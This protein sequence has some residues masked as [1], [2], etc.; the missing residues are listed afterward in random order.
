[1]DFSPAQ[2]LQRLPPY[3]FAE[4]DRRKRAAIAAGRDIIDFG[5][6][7]PEQ[8]TYAYIRERMRQALDDPANHRYPL[9]GGSPAFRQAIAAFFRRRYGVTIAP[10]REVLALL[11]SK[12]GLGHL[13]LAVVDPGQTVLIP[14]P[15]YPVY[16]SSTIFAGATPHVMPLT[17]QR[18]WLPD[19]DA[20]PTAVARAAKLMYLNYPNNPTGAMA[21]REF[22]AQAVAFAR[23]HNII[24]AHDAAYNDMYFDER[25]RPPS[26]LEVPEA[27]EVAVELHSLSK[28]FNMTGWRIGFAVGNADVLAA[29]AKIKANL[30]SGVFGAIQEAGIEAYAGIDRPE[31]TQ[32]LRLYRQRADILAQGLREMGFRVAPPR[33]TFYIWAGLP[34]GYDSMAAAARLLEEADIVCVPGVGFGP[35]GDGYIR[36]ALTV[37]TERTH[38]AIVR[39]RKLRW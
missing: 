39:M 20:I 6:G 26:V 5:V 11:G 31:R 16:H 25:D 37:D 4:I 7:D 36:F 22:F 14:D 32:V 33:A 15:G 30:D 1:M 38:A 21:S 29:L 12:E 28:T 13:T 3:L 27:R 17:E 8:P 35:S 19:L 10:D 9:G 2:R 24:L 18:G 23:R 34:R